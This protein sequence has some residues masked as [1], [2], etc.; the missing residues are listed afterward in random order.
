MS[1]ATKQALEAAMY[2]HINDEEEDPH[3]ITGWVM[4]AATSAFSGEDIGQHSYWFD[5]REE[6]APHITRGLLSMLNNWVE[7]ADD[8][9]D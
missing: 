4:G 1:A 3:L 7:S 8:E 2:A 6:Q 5:S 9:D